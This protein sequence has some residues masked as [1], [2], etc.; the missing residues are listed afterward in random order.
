MPGVGAGGATRYPQFQVFV[1]AAL[2]RPSDH[3]PMQALFVRSWWHLALRGVV[4][5]LF[6]V[7]ALAW[8][9]ATLLFLVALFAA[10]A[11]LSGIAA[12]AGGLRHRDERG[13]WLP[14]AFGIVSLAAGVIAI[15][16][17]GITALA[18]VLIM[19]VNALIGGVLDIAMA[20]RL[21]REIQGEWLLAVAGLV[22]ILFGVL[23]LAV[24]AA[25]VFAL[26]WLVAL[27]AIVAGV[28]L[29][30]TS[31]RLRSTSRRKPL[32]PVVDPIDRT[33]AIVGHK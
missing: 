12:I 18:L 13:W 10:Y 20:V 24:P 15:F 19:G 27:Y 2:V 8:P 9:G 17:P 30:A 28:L 16:Y 26:V 32:A 3:R 33:G 25:G 5:I 14:L 7:L 29:I 31:L 6:G 22:S 23:V 1:I 4:A 21:R 11:V